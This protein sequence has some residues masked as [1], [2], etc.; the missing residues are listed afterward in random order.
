MSVDWVVSR[1]KKR[2]VSDRDTRLRHVV[3][4]LIDGVLCPTS[5]NRKISHV[6]AD[7]SEDLDKFL[8]YPWGTLCFEMTI[9]SIRA[10]G[11]DKLKR[12]SI[13]VQ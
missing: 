2:L 5:G 10:Q 8:N 4:A 11:A 6:H 7:M 3:L 13:T 9:R 12:K 1:L